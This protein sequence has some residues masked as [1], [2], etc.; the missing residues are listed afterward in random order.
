MAPIQ[1]QRYLS[2][3]VFRGLT[4]ALMILV[5][6]PGSWSFV[7]PPLR[8]AEWHGCT[9][10][11]L[12]FPFFIFIVGASIYFSLRKYGDTLNRQVS[13]RVLKRFALIFLI[14]LLLNFF[15]F[16]N[17]SF[18]ELRLFGVLQRIAMAY[19]IATVIIYIGK[20]P[21]KIG[22]MAL[23]ILIIYPV[24]L[25]YGISF[26]E[27]YSLED[28]LVRKID[29]FLVGENHV[30]KGFGIPFDPEGFL[31]AFPAAINAVA[32][33]LVALYITNRAQFKIQRLVL[34]GL[35]SVIA[36]LLLNNIIPINKPLWTSSYV[37]YTSGIAT[38]LLSL[39]IFIIDQK[40][41]QKW[42]APLKV[43]GTNALFAYIISVLWV[44]ILLTIKIQGES[45]YRILYQ[46][47]FVPIA[48]ELHGSFL[49][50]LSH[51]IFFWLITYV[52]YR[53]KIFIKV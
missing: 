9:P 53:K 15:P 44:K 30:Y 35:F 40:G 37:L 32:G 20:S 14:G 16:F 41:F 38:L 52:L 47:I 45:G 33:Y 5:N 28:N 43:F 46:K 25:T 1:N 36:G 3:D 22:A 31:S 7:Y 4:I 50:A 12:V 11:D 29:L 26:G 13:N 42:A 51:V 39:F 21:I 49:F 24:L 17:K 23:V 2:L 48:G 19:L 6:T 27:P 34:I 18:S 8:H 10:T